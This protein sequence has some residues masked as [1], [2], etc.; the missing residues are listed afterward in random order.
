MYKTK[1][2]AVVMF[3]VIFFTPYSIFPCTMA[4]ISGKATTDGRA[5]LLKLRDERDEYREEVKYYKPEGD[6]KYGHMSVVKWGLNK[7]PS[8][9]PDVINGA[10]VNDAGF[11]ISNTTV[12]NYNIFAEAT[13]T[14]IALV[15]Y[16]I[17]RCKTLEDFENILNNWH[18]IK[19]FSTINSNFAV[20]DANGKPAMYE[21]YTPIQGAK[22]IWEKF[23]PD[24]A[25]DEDGNF[26]GF[27][28]R[29]NDNQWSPF[30]GGYLREARLND[31]LIELK[32]NNNL[33]Y[34]TLMNVAAR[35]VCGDITKNLL[36]NYKTINMGIGSGETNSDNTDIHNFNTEGC[37]SK[38]NTRFGFIAVHPKNTENKKLLTAWI[39]LGE[40]DVGI[41]T[42]YFP[43]TKE[44]PPLAWA[45]PGSTKDKIIDENSSSILNELIAT[46]G[47]LSVYDN[48][49]AEIV[50]GGL[51]A[52]EEVDPTIDLIKLKE[53]QSRILPLQNDII[54]QTETF[55]KTISKDKNFVTDD[56][57]YEFSKEM[58]KYLYE[59]Y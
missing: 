55:L 5:L 22:V 24:E 44:V 52:S 29:T 38:Y 58:T 37:I 47:K 1:I 21:A 16:A 7:R 12:S 8:M 4:V 25:Y 39:S 26:L 28:V 40:P 57:L 2:L 50:L 20:L 48:L 18:K 13:N 15:N 6:E 35:D 41:F 17:T 19:K 51:F 31:I 46:K 34:K 23:D 32:L 49:K 11:T 3:L 59:N 27:I 56:R 43:L 54:N 42:P 14:N 36:N 45:D 9:F 33:N 53:I 30:R 10:G